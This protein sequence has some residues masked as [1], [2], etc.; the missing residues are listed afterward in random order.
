MKR[1][2][3][4]LRVAPGARP[5]LR[6][7]DAGRHFGWH[8]QAALAH[9]LELKA[10]LNVLQHRLLV[11]GRFGLLIVLQAIDGGGKDST[12]HHV[13]S[14]FNPQGCTVTSFKTPSVE[15]ARHDYL[16]RVHAHVPARGEIGVFNR[17]HYEE[18]LI[19]RVDALIEPPVWRARYEQ[20]NAFEATLGA[21]GITVLKFFLHISRAEQRRRFEERLHDRAKNWKL[22][23]DDLRKRTQWQ[24]YRHA[25][26]DMLER[27]STR[28]AP[29][30]AVP[31]NHKW[32]RDLAVAQIIADTLEALPLRLPPPRFNPQ[33]LR[34]R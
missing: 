22:E 17:S 19:A 3:E 9:T 10:R 21:E 18:V 29:W 5:S 1:F 27:C 2:R 34:I 7:A 23:A 33:R 12:V 24:A 28:H 15:E 31:A 30:Y 25:F 11:D 13:I 20:I 4:L 8:E 16:W 26:Q 32:L 14:A 6:D